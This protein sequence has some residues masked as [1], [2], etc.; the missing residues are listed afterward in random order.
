VT[1]EEIRL[2]IPAEEDFRPIAHLVTGGLAM[3]LDVT[4]DDLDDLQVGQR[5]T[6]GSHLLDEAQIKK[7]ASEFDPQ[8]FHLDP[9]AA[10][11]SIFGGLIASGWYSAALFMRL[12]VDGLLSD[13][14]A[15]GSP[16]AEQV[17]WLLPLRPGDRVSGRFTVLDVRR[18]RSRPGM[19]VVRSRGELINQTG[20]VVLQLQATG[21]FGCRPQGSG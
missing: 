14:A 7:F 12:L 19:G 13:V 4:Y 15:L 10:R 11:Q 1:T 9:Q 8:P 17:R 21:F 5:F 2:V 3:R 18:S 6:S 16:G 20:V